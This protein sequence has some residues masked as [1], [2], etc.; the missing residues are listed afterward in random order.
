MNKPKFL[1]S[2][3]R[4]G[5]PDGNRPEM[6]GMPS[7]HYGGDL[8]DFSDASRRSTEDVKNDKTDRANALLNRRDLIA[9]RLGPSPKT[10]LDQMFGYHR[11]PHHAP[12]VTD[13]CHL[14]RPRYGWK[15]VPAWDGVAG[16]TIPY[17]SV[18]IRHPH[19]WPSLSG[20]AGVHTLPNLRRSAV[21][22]FLKEDSRFDSFFCFRLAGPPPDEKNQRSFTVVNFDHT[23]P[24]S[25]S[26]PSKC[27]DLL[28]DL[29]PFAEHYKDKAE[30]SPQDQ[31]FQ[32]IDEAF[33]E[34]LK[35]NGRMVAYQ[36]RKD[37]STRSMDPSTYGPQ[38][39]TGK[40]KRQISPSS[41]NDGRSS[42]QR[43]QE[44]VSKL[45]LSEVPESKVSD[46]ITAETKSLP[47]PPPMKQETATD[48]RHDSPTVAI[49]SAD[50]RQCTQSR[51]TELDIQVRRRVQKHYDEKYT[52]KDLIKAV[53]RDTGISII[54]AEPPELSLS[55]RQVMAN[56]YQGTYTEDELLALLDQDFHIWAKD[57]E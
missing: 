27:V 46:T 48:P 19:A 22:A 5:E 38:K 21:K 36:G 51:A 9:E 7:G 32:R 49:V 10:S 13:P 34:W 6:K 42:R 11:P 18:L 15:D 39:P 57:A 43:L 14:P 53:V 17:F 33:E 35:D 52:K 44:S 20:G 12:F 25:H 29:M 50:L 40:R 37:H 41:E 28:R 8:S 31:K 54:G 30:R 56:R 24:H 16:Y 23:K 26:V 2:S 55:D 45:P 4:N 1:K 47:P 3:H